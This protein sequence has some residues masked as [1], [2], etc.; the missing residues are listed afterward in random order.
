MAIP[1]SGWR[2]RK[3]V[4]VIL[5]V[6]PTL[7]VIFITISLGWYGIITGV[8]L[9]AAWVAA[10]L[11][12]LGAALTFGWIDRLAPDEGQPAPADRPLPSQP[13]GT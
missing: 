5:M 11:V 13:H 7:A 12:L 2:P 6:V 9:A 3:V 8:D 10:G 1:A 4:G